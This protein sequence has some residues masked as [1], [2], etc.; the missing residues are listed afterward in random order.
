MRISD[1][2][3]D[4][5]S[6]DLAP[7]FLPVGRNDGPVLR[8][9]VRRKGAGK[10][11]CKDRCHQKEGHAGERKMHAPPIQHYRQYEIRGDRPDKREAE[12]RTAAITLLHLEVFNA[13]Q[14]HLRGKLEEMSAGR[15]EAE[16]AE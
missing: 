2:S 12:K 5:C 3:S 6:S 15:D 11:D 16:R 14:S 7:Q 8:F 10:E 1:W 13:A 9:L 4:V